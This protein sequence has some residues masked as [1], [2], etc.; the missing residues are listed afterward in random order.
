MRTNVALWASL[1]AKKVDHH[2]AS[3]DWSVV[4]FPVPAGATD[5]ELSQIIDTTVP[6]FEPVQCQPKLKK[7]GPGPPHARHRARTR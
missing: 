6:R 1:Y 2:R 7:S 5:E 4:A 3:K